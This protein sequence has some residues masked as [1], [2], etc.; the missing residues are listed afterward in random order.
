M[1]SPLEYLAAFL[2]KRDDAL[3][4]ALTVAQLGTVYNTFET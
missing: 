4:P 2:M 1:P 3:G